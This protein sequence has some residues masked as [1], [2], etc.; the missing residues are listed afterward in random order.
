MSELLNQFKFCDFIHP[1]LRKM[2][3]CF[4]IFPD[5]SGNNMIF[6]TKD[7]KVFG[8]GQNE[9]GLC[10]LGH[11]L[12][13]NDPQMIQELSYKNI[14]QFYNGFDFALAQTKDNKVQS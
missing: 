8:L 9:S 12:V 7:D 13:V 4:Y 11:E 10:G 5:A 2:I 3:N 6:V 14:Q 1:Q